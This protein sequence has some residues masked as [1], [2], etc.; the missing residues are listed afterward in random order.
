MIGELS[1]NRQIYEAKV[2]EH[3]SHLQGIYIPLVFA[4]ASAIAGMYRRM[5]F[6]SYR[7]MPLSRCVA[8]DEL[9]AA[10]AKAGIALSTSGILLDNSSPENVLANDKSIAVIDFE[11]AYI[12]DPPSAAVLEGYISNVDN[13]ATKIKTEGWPLT[14]LYPDY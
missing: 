11:T 13:I 8:N 2:Y 10:L 9:V 12:V 3:L 1:F 14:D 7:G 6:M 4:K 5:I